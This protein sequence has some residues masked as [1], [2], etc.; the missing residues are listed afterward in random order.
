MVGDER[1]NGHATT[2]LREVGDPFDLP[3]F[4]PSLPVSA[5]VEP[6]DE[7]TRA[8]HA[9]YLA[10]LAVGLVSAGWAPRDTVEELVTAGGCEAL[11]AQ[12]ARAVYPM[13]IGD[14]WQRQR[15]RTLLL[16]AANRMRPVPMAKHGRPSSPPF[17][18]QTRSAALVRPRGNL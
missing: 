1:R 16:D 15:A 4:A 9:R 10:A 17:D 6:E 7:P 3:A 11:L 2:V 13:R 5:R 14:A 8:D 12:A 18:R